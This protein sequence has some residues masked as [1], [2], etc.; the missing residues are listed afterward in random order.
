[1]TYA[2]LTMPRNKGYA[3]MKP[4][5]IDSP[6]SSVQYS[7]NIMTSSVDEGGMMMTS[8]TKKR[9]SGRPPAPPPRYTSPPTAQQ[10]A[11]NSPSPQQQQQEMPLVSINSHASSSSLPIFADRKHQ[12]QR[13]SHQQQQ[14][15][16]DSDS[17]LSPDVP[18][19]QDG[20]GVGRRWKQLRNRRETDL[21][22]SDWLSA[23]DSLSQQ[24]K[25]QCLQQQ[26]LIQQQQWDIHQK[27]KVLMGRMKECKTEG[28]SNN[29]HVSMDSSHTAG[30]GSTGS[31]PADLL[32]KRRVL[33]KTLHKVQSV[34]GPMAGAAAPLP[35]A[36]GDKWGSFP[37][38]ME[39]R[40]R[41]TSQ[42]STESA[43]AHVGG[44]QQDFITLA[45]KRRELPETPTRPSSIQ[46]FLN[47]G[48]G[49]AGIVRQQSLVVVSDGGGIGSPVRSE[50]L[51]S[52]SRPAYLRSQSMEQGSYVPRS[53]PAMQ[54]AA[55]ANHGMMF[56]NGLSI[57]HS[58]SLDTSNESVV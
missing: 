12:Q 21:I 30:T 44:R 41:L 15:Q 58:G 6:N 56:K 25:Q 9:S 8:L 13:R 29:M 54:K 37:S 32:E 50:R 17:T 10:R 53:P 20:A 11:D 36:V 39:R 51:V 46:Q 16:Q 45:P 23:P 34:A 38:A 55:G 28:T 7:P 22:G 5:T 1:M 14:K 27:R 4:R 49:K 19:P 40:A 3:P 18:L 47:E 48:G 33:M 2:E 24:Q 43:A 35:S 26:Q 57:I 31:V 52:Q 42:S